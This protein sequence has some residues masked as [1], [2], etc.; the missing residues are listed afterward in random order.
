MGVKS[1]MVDYKG[2]TN[3]VEEQYKQI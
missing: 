2:I 1:T 3:Q